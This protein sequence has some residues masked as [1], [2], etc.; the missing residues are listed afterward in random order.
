MKKQIKKQPLAKINQRNTLPDFAKP[1]FNFNQAALEKYIAKSIEEAGDDYESSLLNLEGG[2]KEDIL[3]TFA[4]TLVLAQSATKKTGYN[5]KESLDIDNAQIF[6]G[7]VYVEKNLSVFDPIIVLGNL[8]VDGTIDVDTYTFLIVRGQIKTKGILNYGFICCTQ[9]IEVDEAIV[10]LG[11]AGSIYCLS[12]I[13]SKLLVENNSS[14]NSDEIIIGNLICTYHFPAERMHNE[15][16][17][18]LLEL[19][20]L[21]V[22]AVLKESSEEFFA[23][24]PLFDFIKQ[25]KSIWKAEPSAVSENNLPKAIQKALKAPHIKELDLS[26]LTLTKLPTELFALTELE[27]LVISHNCL[28][29]IP[30]EIAHLKKLEKLIAD[31]NQISLLP[32]KLSALTALQILDLSNNKLT[33]LPDIFANLKNLEALKLENNYLK[34]LPE[35]VS[36]LICLTSLSLRKNQFEC[37]PAEISSLIKLKDFNIYNNPLK[38]TGQILQNLQSLKT[39]WIG[40]SIVKPATFL[41]LTVLGKLT[42][43]ENL[44]IKGIQFDVFPE[45]VFNLKQLQSLYLGHTRIRQLPEWIRELTELRDLNFDH[46]EIETIP[47]AL[48]LD[49]K[50]TFLETTVFPNLRKDEKQKVNSLIL[51]KEFETAFYNKDYETLLY[52]IKNKNINTIYPLL[53]K[54]EADF[55]HKLLPGS[56][57]EVF[58]DKAYELML[59]NKYSEAIWLF[60]LAFQIKTDT[61]QHNLSIYCNALYAL[62]HD[63]SGLPINSK[64]NYAFLE[65]CLPFGPK[66]PAIYFNAACVYA[67]MNA[68]EQIYKCVKLAEEYHY[69]NFDGMMK[70]IKTDIL[71]AALR[72]SDWFKRY[73]S[74]ID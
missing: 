68:F 18:V 9:D 33:I 35:S 5:Y 64:R 70:S 36:N 30:D 3:Y 44:Y 38:E 55:I 12:N 20:A 48:I 23:A 50:I 49:T 22:V 51:Q 45:F 17:R 6:Y 59:Q 54:H 46:A 29:E 2:N 15:F 63:N 25:N 13:I 37:L 72:E 4:T 34:N 71:F 28:T 27:V 32:Q 43:L 62:Q 52:K 40:T 58:G 10:C 65:K 39:L 31:N 69:K 14:G 47:D 57:I 21:L 56:F 61:E 24:E 42:N 74:C 53:L 26:G 67:E 41:D 8:I 11:N 73:I 19:K 66:N 60:Q 16:K 1:P 7:D